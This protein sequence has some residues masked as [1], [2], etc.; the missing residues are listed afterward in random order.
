MDNIKGGS[1]SQ[2][3]GTIDRQSAHPVYAQLADVLRQQIRDG[4]YRPGDQLPSEAML[5]RTF[6][7]SPM[8]VRRAINLLSDQEIVSTAQGRGTFVKQVELAT[9]A[10][11]LG[12]IKELFS[13]ESA[14]T[15]KL[16]DGRIITA[17]GRTARKLELTEGDT[18]IYIRRLI[19]VDGE[20]AFYHRGYLIYD[21][22]RPIIESEL[23]VTELRCLFEGSGS[24]LIKR[25]ELTVEGVLMNDEEARILKLDLPCPAMILEHIFF[26][27]NDL[28]I[29]WGTF[30]CHAKRLRLQ[31]EVGLK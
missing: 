30:I 19:E 25:G 8:T 14:T 28:P 27:F 23:E 26:D 10:F 29:S 24:S 1:A 11:D 21:P 20:P 17:D 4:M 18:V 5:V 13:N 31:T 2:T 6:H 15:I 12:G 9:A 7:V 16:L 3:K 22:E